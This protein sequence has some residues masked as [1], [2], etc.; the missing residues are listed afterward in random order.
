MSGTSKG[1][2]GHAR[3][4]SGLRYVA[5]GIGIV[6]GSILNSLP[7]GRAYVYSSYKHDSESKPELCFCKCYN[8][9]DIV[10]VTHHR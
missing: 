10:Y 2:Y 1:L 3:D 8:V 4:I 9:F 6:S 7:V 5:S